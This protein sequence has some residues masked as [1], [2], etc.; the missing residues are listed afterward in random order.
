MK[1]H[2][3]TTLPVSTHTMFLSRKRKP[4][5]AFHL[6]K[7]ALHISG[8]LGSNASANSVDLGETAPKFDLCLYFLPFSQHVLDTF[9]SCLLFKI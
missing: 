1:K 2:L 7:Y 9:T 8:A 6:K 5:N 3:V 4:I